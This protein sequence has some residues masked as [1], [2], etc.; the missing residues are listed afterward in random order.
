MA[1]AMSYRSRAQFHLLLRNRDAA[2]DDFR[3][4][5][6]TQTEN[7]PVRPPDGRTSLAL[8][9]DWASVGRLLQAKEDYPAA[10]K[11]YRTVVDLRPDYLDAYAWLA[12]IYLQLHRYPDAI[13]ACNE[14]LERHDQRTGD[15]PRTPVAVVYRTRGQAWAGSGA[16]D[17]Q[18]AMRD[19]L[20][21]LSYDANDRALQVLLGQTSLA[22]RDYRQA[23]RAFDE[24]IRL[25]P[26]G[27]DGYLGR[28]RAR[29]ELGD[30]REAVADAEAALDLGPRTPNVL[31][32][33]AIVYAQ[34]L[35]GLV[36][37]GE[38]N[39]QEHSRLQERYQARALALL[40]E[41]LRQ[42]PQREAAAF[43]RGSIEPDRAFDP[44][45]QASELAEL[46]RV[47]GPGR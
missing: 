6:R 29:A 14:Y 38:L 34:A 5:V 9:R 18:A 15:A 47:Y 32:Q 10:E 7:R 21:G 43:W 3:R 30:H 37:V 42:L 12:D 4:A 35:R 46:R 45:R 36:T 40:R 19:Y 2:L 31:R 28:G 39:R 11:A 26:R 24:A 17:L 8:A 23:E 41:A 13:A 16:P 27:I 20:R 44:I 1:L 25:N 33:A 22:A